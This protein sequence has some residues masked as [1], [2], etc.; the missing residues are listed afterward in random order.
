MKNWDKIIYVSF[1]FIIAV[2]SSLM[3]SYAEFPKWSYVI[4]FI[5]LILCILNKDKITKNLKK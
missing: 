3:G 2:V 1:F 4:V 5:I